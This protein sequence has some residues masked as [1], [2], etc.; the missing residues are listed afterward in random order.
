MSLKKSRF[1]YELEKAKLAD[2]NDEKLEHL[3]EELTAKKKNIRE[4]VHH[5]KLEEFLQEGFSKLDE[6]EGEYRQFHERN[7]DTVQK[8]PFAII[9]FFS[10]LEKELASKFQLVDESK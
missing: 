2:D 9:E 7:M 8:H 6:V 3:N 1:D 5:P 4:A 10:G